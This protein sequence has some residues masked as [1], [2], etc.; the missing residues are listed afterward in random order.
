MLIQPASRHISVHLFYYCF[1]RF[2]YRY[3]SVKY[4]FHFFQLLSCVMCIYFLLLNICASPI[5]L[6]QN[7]IPNEEGNRL[8]ILNVIC[9]SACP[10]T[11]NIIRRPCNGKYH[12]RCQM[13]LLRVHRFFNWECCLEVMVSHE[14]WYYF[15]CPVFPSREVFMF[16]CML[17]GFL[18]VFPLF[19]CLNPWGRV[20]VKLVVMQLV[21]T[22]PA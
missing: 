20:H 17:I 11:Q 16:R 14:M 18:P 1:L 19:L 3:Y 21:K 13:M 12:Q 9:K 6:Q 7:I 22:S 8:E 4:T 10:N 5:N 2:F 15:L